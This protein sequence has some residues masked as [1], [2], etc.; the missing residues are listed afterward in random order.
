M[1]LDLV[2]KTLLNIPHN[3]FTQKQGLDIVGHDDL[4]PAVQLL[5]NWMSL[6]NWADFHTTEYGRRHL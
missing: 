2:K 4:D 6:E 5:W 3:G 1:Y